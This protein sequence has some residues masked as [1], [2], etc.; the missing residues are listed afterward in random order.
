M[1]DKTIAAVITHLLLLAP[2]MFFTF[3]HHWTTVSIENHHVLTIR[4]EHELW[5]DGHDLIE[6]KEKSLIDVNGKTLIFDHICTKYWW[7][8]LQARRKVWNLGGARSTV[9]GIIC[10]PGWDRI[11]CLAKNWGS[12][13]PEATICLTFVHENYHKIDYDHGTETTLENLM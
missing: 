5:V 11:N 7:E 8:V 13:P 10:P 6:K 12:K 4:M 3:R 1:S 9:V 2:Q